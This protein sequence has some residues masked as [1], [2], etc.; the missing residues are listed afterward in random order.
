MCTQ[1]TPLFL[2]ALHTRFCH[3]P[4]PLFHSCL[5]HRP[6][7]TTSFSQ[8]LRRDFNVRAADELLRPIAGPLFEEVQAIPAAAAARAGAVVAVS[9]E[10]AAS[11]RKLRNSEGKTSVKGS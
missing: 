5:S 11:D 10:S 6:R 1:D 2:R 8:L 4:T 3:T 9:R 7:L